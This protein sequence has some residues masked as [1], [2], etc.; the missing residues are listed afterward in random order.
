MVVRK[1]TVDDVNAIRKL[2]SLAFEMIDQMEDEAFIDTFMNHPNRRQQLYWLERWGAFDDEGR[3]MSSLAA[4]P[5]QVNFDGQ[6]VGMAGIAD[7]ASYP[8]YRNQ[9]AVRACFSKAFRE[10][11]ERGQVFSYLYPFSTAYYQKFGY[12][13]CYETQEWQIQ[14]DKLPSFGTKG[15]YTLFEKGGDIEPFVAIYNRFASGYNMAVAREEIDWMTFKESDCFAQTHYTYLYRNEDGIPKSFFTFNKKYEDGI[16]VMASPQFVFYDAEGL[17]GILDFAQ[18]LKANYVSIR[19]RVPSS[20]QIDSFI[21]EHSGNF[22]VRKIAYSGMAR[23]VDVRRA[24]SIARF[25]GSGLVVLKIHDHSCTWNDGTF[26]V[27]FTDG[28]MESVTETI[29]KPDIELGIDLFTIL[30]LGK[31][32]CDELD[33]IDGLTVNGNIANLEKIFYKK[34]IA[35]LDGF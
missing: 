28:K 3:L 4:Y 30:L 9:G 24:L 8:Q 12:V 13:P 25:K 14:L 33:F 32:N 27:N 20:L 22:A 31:Y 5:Y 6:T 15:G 19:F 34:R 10:M 21:K 11:K 17:K 7:V 16:S 26:A 18:R 1:V 2:K 29:D 35:I 23:V